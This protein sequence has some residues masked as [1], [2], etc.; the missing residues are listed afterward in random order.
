VRRKGSQKRLTAAL[1]V[2]L[3][4]V[5]PRSGSTGREGVPD[6]P[7]GRELLAGQLLI[8]Q[9]DMKDP[10]FR[11][12]V[13]FMVRHNEEGALGLVVNKAMGFANFV[14]LLEGM[15]ADPENIEGTVRLHY[16]GPVDPKRGFVLHTTDYGESPSIPVNERYAVTIN[17]ELLKAMARGSGPK[18]S[19]LAIGYTG[20]GSGQLERELARGDWA[21]APASEEI[22]FDDDYETKWKRALEGRYI[23]T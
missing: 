12:T 8:A 7:P 4:L 6:L 10:R 1:F 9:P 2:L 16:G 11:R 20:W 19:L 23:S 22:L 3:C 15:G 21:I 14:D 5:W 18:H 13:V 17:S